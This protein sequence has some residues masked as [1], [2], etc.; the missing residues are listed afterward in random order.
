MGRIKLNENLKENIRTGHGLALFLKEHGVEYVFGIPDG[1]TL[2]FYD[3]ILQI[4]GIEHI[5]L[6]DE[7]SAAF[8][9]DA[10]ARVTGMLGVCDAGSA[11]SMNFPVALSEANGSAS[12]VLA[13]VGTI[14]SKESL[15]N[16][17]HDINVEDTLTPLTKWCEKVVDSDYLPRFLSYAIKLATT[18]R[19][20]PVSLVISED[21]FTEEKKELG[22]FIPQVRGS[23]SINSCRPVAAR[24]EID[25]ALNMIRRSKQP[26]IYAG[27]GAVLSGAFTEIAELSRF[28]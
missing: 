8:A 28:L 19:P 9:A 2:A 21:V 22:D 27:G 10:Y 16:I 11:G 7:R 3:G 25:E 5:L 24:G 13:L 15:R 23:C 20:G 12:P 1:H 4:E 26:V 18:G 14:K 6:N 17:P